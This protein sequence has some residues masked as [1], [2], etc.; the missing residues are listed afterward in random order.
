MFWH[1]C[2]I[3]AEKISVE[4]LSRQELKRFLD[5]K[6]LQYSNSRFMQDDPVQIPHLFDRQEDIEIAGF[7]TATISWGKRANIIQSA[8]SL[9]QRMDCAPAEFISQA[10]EREFAAFHD[11]VYRTF[12][13]VDVVYFLRALQHVYRRYGGIGAIFQDTYRQTGDLKFSLARFNRLFFEVAPPGRTRKHVAD[14]TQNSAAKRLNM[15]LRW[16]VRQ[17]PRGVD[18]GLWRQIP[19]SA[20]Y[21]PLD[22]HS[23]RVA[24]SL[25]LLTRKQNDWKAVEEVT[26]RLRKLDAKDPVK[27]DFALFGLG[28]YEQFQ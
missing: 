1:I 18:F 13:P 9:F 7:I 2:I 21:L 14:V 5:E 17:D 4:K 6:Y 12:Q 22:V 16:M 19:Q 8:R 23:G 26:E 28:V 24:R 25:G 3:F 27:Y 20:L 10:D 11:F 15:Y